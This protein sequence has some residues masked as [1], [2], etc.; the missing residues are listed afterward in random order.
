[1]EPQMVILSA[2]PRE[3][4]VKLETRISVR[5]D[6]A[7]EM[8]IFHSRSG[9]VI[10]ELHLGSDGIVRSAR[11]RTSTNVITQPVAKLIQLEPE[12]FS[13]GRETPPYGGQDVDDRNGVCR[14]RLLDVSVKWSTHIEGHFPLLE[15]STPVDDQITDSSSVRR[16]TVAGYRAAHRD[17]LHFDSATKQSWLPMATHFEEFVADRV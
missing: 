9:S 16:C 7:I 3:L 5:T 8:E 4:V 13:D 2:A 11:I 10:T 17:L 1:M 12:T 6:A 14:Q 15:S